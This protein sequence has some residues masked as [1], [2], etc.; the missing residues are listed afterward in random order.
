MKILKKIMILLLIIG[1]VFS[2][3]ACTDESSEVESSEEE[4]KVT[5]MTEGEYLMEV[6]G[7]KAMTV[8]VTLSET[9]VESIEVV[10]HDET[11]GVS[12]AALENIPK[13]IIEKQ[14]LSVDVISGAT[15][16]SN[17]IITAVMNA[18]EEA[19]GVVEEFKTAEAGDVAD[20]ASSDRPALGS[21]EIPEE[22]DYTYDV[23]VVG[24]GFSGLAAA[25][26]ASTEGADTLLI[27]KMPV[28]GGN[29]QINGGVYSSY[30]SSLADDLYAKLNLEPDSPE[31]H[32]EDTMKGGD[33][34]SDRKLVE[35]FVYGSPVFLDMM[36]ENGLEV[37]ESIT[38]PGGH[39]GFRMYTTINGIGA[40]IVSV[41]RKM[42][43]DTSTE[44]M[45]NTKMVGIYRDNTEEQR[46]VGIRV[47]TNDGIKN[48]KAEN[49][50]VL[51][52]GGFSGNAQMR[53]THVPALTEDL[54]TSNHVG[55]TGE[56][57]T[58]AQAIGAGTK[59]MSYIQL[60]PFSDPEN[61]RLDAAALIPFSGPSSG[62]VYVDVEG[63]RYVN[64]G[65]RRDV[66][67]QAAQESGGFPT[68]AIF[69][70]EIVEKGGFIQESQLNEMI[71]LERI[72]KAD[73]LEELAE[74]INEHQY[75]GG[76]VSMP[77]ESLKDTILKHNSYIETGED[78]DFGKR[79]DQGVMLPIDQ[80]PYYAV[81]QWPSVHHTMGGLTISHRTEV[82]D[83][84][85]EVIPGLFAAGEVVGGVHG[86]NRLGSNAIPDAAV[87]GYIAG[88]MAASGTLP[89]FVPER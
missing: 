19:G 21:G 63:N 59:H 20:V 15:E 32:I 70:Q 54:L 4:S 56:G 40:D 74:I 24:G 58:I 87:H 68:F 17:G 75:Q 48:I 35:N 77:G 6:T 16:T 1:M 33:N 86:S 38:R 51:T 25:Q 30:T 29:S 81:P 41:Q 9:T 3:A 39:S 57:I 26:K 60:Y 52:T 23:V 62:V 73:T 14:S 61:G 83:I 66:C 72:F 42:L 13:E 11:Q 89:D 27:D 49:G 78:L 18:I 64:E 45:L 67:A 84:Y 2:L 85:G 22:W 55:A 71:E 10:D 28:L 47:E 79:I 50:V 31:V 12:D 80:A 82:Q 7:Y 53:E 36:L 8:K 44:I 37:R 65:G 76:S 34:L 5:P 88:Q 43:D 46:V 69:G